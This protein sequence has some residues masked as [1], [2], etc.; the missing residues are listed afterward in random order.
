MM[1]GSNLKLV[2]VLCA[3]AWVGITWNIA[4][5]GPGPAYE[6]IAS[7]DS[8]NR[9]AKATLQEV[10][11][12]SIADNLEYCGVIF[13]D[14]TGSLSSSKVSQGDHATCEFDWGV[15]LGNH[16][17]ASFHTHAGYDPN[18]D[19]E[20]PSEIDMANDID[21]RIEGFVATPAGRIWHIDWKSA[22]ASQLCG[23]NCIAKDPNYS[24]SNEYPIKTH[25]SVDE[26]IAELNG[27]ESI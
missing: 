3:L 26:L 9:F 19:F 1:D 27:T 10:Q 24:P 7:A 18:Y 13:E 14:A 6:R 12:R 5:R 20:L 15:P 8:L 25:Y 17:V 2:Y 4:T 22:S 16:V 11:A 21:A 23:I